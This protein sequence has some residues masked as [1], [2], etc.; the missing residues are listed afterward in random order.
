[1]EA[2][3]PDIIT[4]QDAVSE[5]RRKAYEI[6]TPLLGL[7]LSPHERRT[8]QSTRK[9]QRQVG[10]YKGHIPSRLNLSSSALS[11]TRSPTQPSS[12]MIFSRVIAVATVG[13]P[14]LAAATPTQLQAR[15]SCSTGAVQCC[16]QT[17]D[18]STQD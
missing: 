6:E 13:L 8:I 7:S 15:Q 10:R 5:A 14:L 11:S 1:M 16:Q 18:V 3:I 2:F 4:S 17:M 9:V 12:T